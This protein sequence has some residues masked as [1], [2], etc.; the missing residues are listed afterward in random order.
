MFPLIFS[1]PVINAPAGFSFPAL[2]K[3]TLDSKTEILQSQYI[4]KLINPS[5]EVFLLQSTS[6]TTAILKIN[7]N[8][9]VCLEQM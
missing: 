6:N 4:T 1:F 2:N 8:I 9:I 7:D 3:K 5:I